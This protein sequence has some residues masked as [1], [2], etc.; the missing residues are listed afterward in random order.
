MSA[1]LYFIF[2][3]IVS[4]VLGG[5]FVYFLLRRR[6]AALEAAHKDLNEA[7]ETL[8]RSDHRR[9]AELDLSLRDREM[10]MVSLHN[11]LLE[12]QKSHNVLKNELATLVASD[13]QFLS[14]NPAANNDKN[15]QALARI[16]EK[17][18]SFDY[19]HMGFATA[20]EADDLKIISGVGPQI[21][22]KLQALGIYT[23]RQVAHFNDADTDAVTRAIEFFPGRIQRDRWVEQCMTLYMMKQ[24]GETL[25]D[26][27]DW[28]APY[29]RK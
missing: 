22:E 5:I 3:N 28:D 8:R 13:A 2:W 19:S 11:Q 20:A 17:S 12:C 6:T 27:F 1:T 23:F 15:T 4:A 25:P 18:A 26:E 7:Y 16:R 29:A 21:A 24:R 10:Q 9:E 14:D